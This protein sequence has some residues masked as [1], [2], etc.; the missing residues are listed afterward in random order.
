MFH[1]FLN[2]KKCTLVLRM[3]GK[4]TRTWL[5]EGNEFHLIEST[6]NLVNHFISHSNI[7]NTFVK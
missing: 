6:A 3:I 4:D 1:T 2:K 7:T 5:N